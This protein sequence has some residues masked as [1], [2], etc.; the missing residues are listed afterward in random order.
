MNKMNLYSMIMELISI[1]KLK[2]LLY[3]Q[4][5]NEYTELILFNKQ[6]FKITF[7]FIPKYK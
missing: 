5:T 2:I 7:V 1:I 3:I 4:K 6:F